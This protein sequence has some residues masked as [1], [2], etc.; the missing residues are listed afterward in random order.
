MCESGIGKDGRKILSQQFP[1]AATQNN[2][3]SRV[4]MV[5][6]GPMCLNRISSNTKQEC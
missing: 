2:E 3:K 1:G 5:G 6:L 4:K